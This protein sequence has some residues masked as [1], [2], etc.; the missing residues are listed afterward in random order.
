MCTRDQRDQHSREY[1]Y[2]SPVP[3]AWRTCFVPPRHRQTRSDFYNI[4]TWNVMVSELIY[5]WC[6]VSKSKAFEYFVRFCFSSEL[7]FGTFHRADRH[8]RHRKLVPLEMIGQKSNK[9]QPKPR[10]SDCV[11]YKLRFSFDFFNSVFTN[12]VGFWL[13]SQPG[14][15]P[16]WVPSKV[17]STC[18]SKI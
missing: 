1:R 9:T 7:I 17:R 3:I 13:W 18:W 12:S 15:L 5:F 10:L 16:G 14:Q 2:Q 8:A 11:A 6:F 4:C